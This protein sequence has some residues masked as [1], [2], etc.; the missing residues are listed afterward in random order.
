MGKRISGL[1]G[2]TVVFQSQ[3]NQTNGHRVFALDLRVEI[4][5]EISHVFIIPYLRY[6]WKEVGSLSIDTE[7]LGKRL[8]DDYA[9]SGKT[10]PENLYFLCWGIEILN[11]ILNQKLNRPLGHPTCVKMMAYLMK[12]F[13]DKDPYL[14]K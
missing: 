8:W 10:V 12:P 13:I 4:S 5:E 2:S 1:I 3:E 7:P 9:K 6:V 11:P 14:N